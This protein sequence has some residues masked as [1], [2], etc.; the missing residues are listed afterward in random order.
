MTQINETDMML[1]GLLAEARR[2]DHALTP[3]V[4]LLARVMADA[5]AELA[6]APARIVLPKR[7]GIWAGL[8]DVIGGPRAFGGLITAG[9][10]GIW[11]GVSGGAQVASYL[12]VSAISVTETVDLMP[13]E[14]VFAMVGGIGG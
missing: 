5:D 13:V 4:D 7:R 8:M 1:D 9:L 14:D 2:R 10:A 12:G 6:V 3:T 11:I